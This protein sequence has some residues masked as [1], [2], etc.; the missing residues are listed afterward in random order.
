MTDYVLDTATLG[1]VTRPDSETYN[2]PLVTTCRYRIINC[3][4]PLCY[5]DSYSARFCV[6]YIELLC[7]MLYVNYILPFTEYLCSLSKTK[8][9]EGRD[10]CK[11]RV[12]KREIRR[13]RT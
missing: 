11:R 8:H 9:N 10:A 3:L 7:I 13:R 12:R 6:D 5:A 1:T 2:C 4:A